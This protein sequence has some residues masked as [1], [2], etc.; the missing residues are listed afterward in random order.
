MSVRPMDMDDK[1]RWAVIPTL[2]LIAMW[3]FFTGMHREQDT[4]V[5]MKA[6]EAAAPETAS[7]C[8]EFTK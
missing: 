5:C 4:K 3:V 2:I 1:L 7:L 8:V 6:I